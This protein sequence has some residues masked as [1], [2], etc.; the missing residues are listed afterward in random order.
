MMLLFCGC[1][2]DWVFD[3]AG[4]SQAFPG[5]I[6]EA[7]R[8]DFEGAI[9]WL[10]GSMPAPDTPHE[11]TALAFLLRDQALRAAALFHREYHRAF[12]PDGCLAIGVE[13]QE[14]CWVAPSCD[15]R[16]KLLQWKHDFLS[17]FDVTHPWPAVVRIATAIRRNAP[18]PFSVDAACKSVGMSRSSLNRAFGRSI[19]SA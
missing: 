13:F 5:K 14:Q 6:L 12:A 3:V 19:E 17:A 18:R 10:A 15:P 2:P 4:T 9:D 7:D 11:F 8:E 1:R 16:V